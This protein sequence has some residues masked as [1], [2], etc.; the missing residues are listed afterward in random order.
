MIKITLCSSEENSVNHAKS[1]LL[2]NG[3]EKQKEDDDSLTFVNK[4]LKSQKQA[5]EELEK[6]GLLTSAKL[7][8]YIEVCYG[9]VCSQVV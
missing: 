5:R 7:K 9:N 1:L 8:I 2:V 3:W 4:R 6:L